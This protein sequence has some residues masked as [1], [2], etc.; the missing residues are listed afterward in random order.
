[1]WSRS[2]GLQMRFPAE[3]WLSKATWKKTHQSI[4][5]V[6][7]VE[8]VSTISQNHNIL[9]NDQSQEPF[10]FSHFS[11]VTKVA[12]PANCDCRP[13]T[14]RGGKQ[15]LFRWRAHMQGGLGCACRVSADPALV[16][17]FSP[18]RIISLKVI[19]INFNSKT[20]LMCVTTPFSQRVEFPNRTTSALF[21]RIYSRFFRSVLLLSTDGS[22]FFLRS[23][24]SLIP[25]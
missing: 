9:F 11:P 16:S 15:P 14:V 24:H 7:E 3:A 13:E 2:G 18:L 8:T 21:V 19:Y 17:I 10:P 4:W 1:M 23:A 6:M 25:L 12:W 22:P 20:G 5:F